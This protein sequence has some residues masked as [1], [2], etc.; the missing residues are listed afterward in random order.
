MARHDSPRDK[1]LSLFDGLACSVREP[2]YRGCAFMKADAE[3]RSGSSITTV[4]DES[5]QW[6]RGLLVDL[7]RGLGAKDP[8]GLAQQLVILYDGASV[9]ARMDHDANAASVARTVAATRIDA[10]ASGSASRS[11]PRHRGTASF[12]L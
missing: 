12:G 1:L 4:C 6:L 2:T 3:V 8:A 9:S 11:R 10:A 5:R 7:A